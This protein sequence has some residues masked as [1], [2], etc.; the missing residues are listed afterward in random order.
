MVAIDRLAAA[1]LEDVKQA[2]ESLDQPT[3]LG[4][5]PLAELP[6]MSPHRDP[7]ELRGLLVDVIT[8]LAESDDPREAES[9]R[10]LLAYYVKRLGGHELNM[11]RLHMSRPTY[12]RRLQQGY[13]RV[14]EQLDRVSEFA[15]LFPL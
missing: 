4:L 2:L 6:V 5:N 8:D 10:L 11:R 12:F 15:R 13:A 3:A 7:A 9:G 14:A 1:S